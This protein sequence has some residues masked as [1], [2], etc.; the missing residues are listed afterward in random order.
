MTLGNVDGQSFALVVSIGVLSLA[1]SISLIGQIIGLSRRGF[2]H[3]TDA[4]IFTVPLPGQKM[5]H[6]ILAFP[7]IVLD[8]NIYNDQGDSGVTVDIH[9]ATDAA[10]RP[11]A[12]LDDINRGMLKRITETLDD[13]EDTSITTCRRLQ[14]HAWLRDVITRATTW[15]VYRPQSPFEEK[16]VADAFCEF[17]KGIMSILIGVLPSI[18]A[19][20]ATAARDKVAKAFLRH[21]QSD[22]LEMASAYA[23]NRYHA[24]VK[25]KITLEDMG[26]FEVGG[27][28]AVL[29]NTVLASAPHDGRRDGQSTGHRHAQGKLPVAPLGLLTGLRYR[30]MGVLVVE[31]TYLDQWLLK[32]AI[33]QMPSPVIHQDASLWGESVGE[34]NPR[35][36]LAE[37]KG[38][39]PSDVCF[40]AFGGEK[41]LW[42][43]NLPTTAKTNAAAVIMG[44]DNDIEV[45]IT[46]RDGFGNV[47]WAVNIEKSDMVFAMVTEDT[48]KTLSQIGT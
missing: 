37:E 22:A 45:E 44:P 23:K 27:S 3:K 26:R 18:T 33:L 13:L 28:L 29:V 40:R 1:L 5:Y 38:S 15:S 11:G 39:R 10:S 20:K 36:F 4:P 16:A 7:P 8:A 17:E 6:R 24:E 31:N 12:H 2:D 19:R 48:D 21:Y 43:W 42:G 46:T 9:D 41:T 47:K 14:L 30:S 34:F 32:E 25:N 35:R